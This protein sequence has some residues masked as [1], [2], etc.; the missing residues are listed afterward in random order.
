MCQQRESHVGCAGS[1]KEPLRP[2]GNSKI[3]F[4][5][6]GAQSFISQSSLITSP[7]LFPSLFKPQLLPSFDKGVGHRS[8]PGFMGQGRRARERGV[9]SLSAPSHR[10]RAESGRRALFPPWPQETHT[11][12]EGR[13]RWDPLI[14]WMPGVL[15]PPPVEPGR[16]EG[17]AGNDQFPPMRSPLGAR[18]HI[19]ALAGGGAQATK[20]RCK[21]G[22][23]VFFSLPLSFPLPLPLPLPPA[24][25]ARFNLQV[26]GEGRRRTIQC[27][28]HTYQGSALPCRMLLKKQILDAF[29]T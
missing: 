27:R 18:L 24:F 6:E 3:T 17:T 13:G 28:R 20:G 10:R 2:G 16:G 25:L 22:W 11:S 4:T 7:S 14:D 1:S 23:W 15:P 5:Q 8:P 29:G 26:R 19:L 21:Q 9:A 12:G